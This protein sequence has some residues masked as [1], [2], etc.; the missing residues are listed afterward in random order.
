MQNESLA[1]LARN[2]NN[3]S[4]EELYINNKGLI[5]I[6]ARNFSKTANDFED[7]QQIAIFAVIDA[8]KAFDGKYKFSTYLKWTLKHH[9]YKY[10][11]EQY[12]IDSA[13]LNNEIY[14]EPTYQMEEEIISCNTLAKVLDCM[15]QTLDEKNLNIV[16]DHVCLGKS[17]AEIGRNLGIG[18]ERVRMR[19]LRALK[20]LRE[21]RDLQRI[22][23]EYFGRKGKIV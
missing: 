17:F 2:G 7:L 16:I 11:T 22:A 1:I 21:N 3:R 13:E 14:A 23:D 12:K 6:A 9:F 10:I 18:R 15:K 19:E 8:V 4:L 20:K 5:T